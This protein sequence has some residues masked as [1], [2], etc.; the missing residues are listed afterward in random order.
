[1][2][3]HDTIQVKMWGEWSPEMSLDM[4]QKLAPDMK[5]IESVIVREVVS[6]ERAQEVVESLTNLK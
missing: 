4:F 2:K 1:M 5:E 3:Q 6:L